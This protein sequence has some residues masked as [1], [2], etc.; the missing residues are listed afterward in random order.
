MSP[1][2]PVVV[3]SGVLGVRVEQGIVNE[4]GNALHIGTVLKKKRVDRILFRSRRLYPFEGRED[5]AVGAGK[6]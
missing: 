2:L 1:S 3:E 6:K 5:E 4:S